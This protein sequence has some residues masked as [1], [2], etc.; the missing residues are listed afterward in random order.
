MSVKN[1]AAGIII[2]L[3]SIVAIFLLVALDKLDNTS[4]P[5]S[6]SVSNK[7]VIYDILKLE[8]LVT[9]NSTRVL[10]INAKTI[11][12]KSESKK[13]LISRNVSAIQTINSNNLKVLEL[14]TKLEN[15]IS[16]YPSVVKGRWAELLSQIYILQKGISLEINRNSAE[17]EKDDI[18]AVLKNV[19]L[20]P[21]ILKGA[22]TVSV[23]PI[24]KID[25]A[26]EII[27]PTLNSLSPKIALLYNELEIST[28]ATNKTASGYLIPIL[29]CLLASISFVAFYFTVKKVS[30]INS[31]T[32]EK[33]D[34]LLD[35]LWNGRIINLDKYENFD[36]NIQEKIHYIAKSR[37]ELKNLLDRLASGKPVDKNLIQ[38]QNE[39]DNIADS[40][41]LISLKINSLTTSN[42]QKEWF[43]NSIKQIRELSY[44]NLNQPDYIKSLFVLLSKD[45][46]LLQ[47]EVYTIKSAGES[48][49]P[50]LEPNININQDVN[51]ISS[52]WTQSAT[53][54]QIVYENN[55]EIN[56]SNN[57]IQN[58][59]KAAFPIMFKG[60]LFGVL[61]I[62]VKNVLDSQQINYLKD[63][64]EVIGQFL[65]SYKIIIQQNALQSNLQDI[66]QQKDLSDKQ[67]ESSQATINTFK[68]QLNT[69]HTDF[70][71]QRL[72]LEQ[73]C[74][75]IEWNEN[76]EIIFCNDL[77]LGF[78]NLKF[79][80]VV[81]KSIVELLTSDSIRSFEEARF[82]NTIKKEAWKGELN[83]KNQN[84]DL[85]LIQAGISPVLDENQNLFKYI[86]IGFNKSDYT[87][88]KQKFDEFSQKSLLREEEMESK[89]AN[90]NKSQ[91][92]LQKAQLVLYGTVNALNNSAIVSETDTQGRIISVNEQFLR[93]SKYSREELINQN[94]RLFKSGHQPDHIFE[95]LW[96][97]L[98]KG[99]V[100]KGEF[101]NRAKD[102]SY[103]WVSATITPVF[104][105]ETIVRYICISF[106]IS[107]QKLQDEQ[108]RA[109]LQLSQAQEAELRLNTEEL[110][111]TQMEMRKTQIELRGQIDAINN[112]GIVAE[113]DLRGNI[114][115]V[116]DAFC[117]ISK[118]SREDL[119]R[120]NHRT[121]KSGE[122]SDEFYTAI[123]NDISKGNVWSGTFK[124]RA[125]DGSF[126]WVHTTITPVLGFDAKPIKYISVSFDTTTLVLQEE[127]LKASLINS[128]NQEETLRA[129]ESKILL[130]QLELTGQIAAIHNASIVSETDSEGNIIGV[131]DKFIILTKYD[132]DELIGVNHRILKSP[133]TD[134]EIFIGLWNTLKQKKIWRGEF[135]NRAKDGTHFWVTATIA[136]VFDAAGEIVKF[137]SIQ[138]DITAIKE[139]EV[140]LI[141]ALKLS[142]QQAIEIHEKQSLMDGI[143]KNISGVIYRRLPDELW[144]MLLISE[145]VETI[146]GISAQAFIN[147][148]KS[149]TEL[150]HTEDLFEL[151][152]RIDQ[153]L[154]QKTSF[155]FTYR[156]YDQ[157][158]KIRWIHE[159]GRGVYNDYGNLLYI[160]GAFF[161]VT[162]EKELEENLRLALEQAQFQ[163]ELLKQNAEIMQQ[164]QIELVGQINALNNAGI[165]S[166]TD[167]NGN[168]TY[169]NDEAIL[170][171]GY[172][173][174]EIIGQNHRILKSKEHKPEFYRKLWMT[175]SSGKVWKGVIKNKSK[176]GEEYW[177]LLTITPVLNIDNVPIKY[178]A[179]GY[180][181][182]REKRQ[183][184][185]I[186]VLFE[187]TR[188]KESES[189]SYADTLEKVQLEMLSARVFQSEQLEIINQSLIIFEIN[190]S[191]VLIQMNSIGKSEWSLD[192]IVSS[193]L[194]IDDLF[195]DYHIYTGFTPPYV[196]NIN[197]TNEIIPNLK[198]MKI[199]QGIL[200]LKSEIK[201]TDI[202]AHYLVTILP[203]LDEN[204]G[205]IR[206]VG[207]AIRNNYI[208][209][210]ENNYR[211]NE[212]GN[213]MENS[214]TTV[215]NS[216]IFESQLSYL[217]N[218]I[219][220][221][222]DSLAEQSTKICIEDF[223]LP[224]L[225]YNL[226]GE[227]LAAN[228]KMRAI[229]NLSEN[230][231]IDFLVSDFIKIPNFTEYTF[232]TSSETK[233]L[234]GCV[235]DHSGSNRY[236]AQFSITAGSG[237]HS[238]NE[239][240]GI[241]PEGY[242][243][244]TI[245]NH[246]VTN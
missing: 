97:S 15:T 192:E 53:S 243:V 117:Q 88:L 220:Y 229:L 98:T 48:I 3:I 11:P 13:E 58:I 182:T 129:N 105:D 71:A 201:I 124:N 110:N 245:N 25:P 5:G 56:K 135:K 63:V 91:N 187:E 8:Q 150:I 40:I 170:K 211:Y 120:K 75:V 107:S 219:T 49:V 102:S 202:F 133:D 149:L 14:I 32:N 76:N 24:Q 6:N 207:L 235:Q 141:E 30:K 59:L 231:V 16:Q 244:L 52:I 79:N 122:H 146:V 19:V 159:E 165:V 92:E 60:E 118:Y 153:A 72:S 127:K 134:P 239:W 104:E 138:F 29:I 125:N 27:V 47:G 191:G 123:W 17:L 4:N 194:S 168:I 2:S 26:G 242:N 34:E 106:N 176:D 227:I 157:N 179:V 163:Q 189:R 43:I 65:H 108:L 217:N 173:R 180:D 206:C 230:N 31:E 46:E 54:R 89:E 188:K 169:I 111:K 197:I 136:P 142:E 184:N 64:T 112:A 78:L 237:T 128:L 214:T 86:L 234:E 185:R 233:L 80:D 84:N 224:T 236:Q 41:E 198:D 66:R 94:H 175:I 199:W 100:W 131:N 213:E 103:F 35:T 210:S 238:K 130:A 93:I 73:V 45:I 21:T 36:K 85:I 57:Q 208:D 225:L 7:S 121:L 119:L 166:E 200:S 33:I 77:T 178:I 167:V 190:P 51:L 68:S 196:S 90:L 99:Q 67:L 241:F 139:Q 216:F 145:R 87:D 39:K 10:N 215:D 109:A 144:T 12:D 203:Q 204:D 42:N 183:A 44:K 164:Q 143:L 154:K 240:I 193:G 23:D 181:I 28:S 95:T 9:E 20:D 222:E 18:K 126:Y 172:N 81:G 55:E 62:Q 232:E 96:E 151:N 155:T 156:V 113:T 137:I 246:L 158:Q 212:T 160:D 83:L 209:Q 37:N 38:C 147:H 74:L 177:S 114:T 101:K 205:L 228:N 115:F 82:N 1:N 226:K 152:N 69:F 161:D 223:P 116:N 61:A 171:W 195:Q 186:K 70:N 132:R 162:L 221:L 218:R 174:E 50:I 140:K 22:L 148:N